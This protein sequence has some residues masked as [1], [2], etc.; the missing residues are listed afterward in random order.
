MASA[1]VWKRAYKEHWKWSIRGTGFPMPGRAKRTR[2][3]TL[4]LIQKFILKFILLQRHIYFQKTLVHKTITTP[5]A[6]TRT[7][8]YNT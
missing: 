5:T 6:T 1:G 4:T 2:K 8:S 7:K 3:K